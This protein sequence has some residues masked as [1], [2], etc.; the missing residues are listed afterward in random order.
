VTTDPP[1]DR[2]GRRDPDRDDARRARRAVLAVVT[3]V[4]ATLVW[5]LGVPW[6]IVAVAV[7]AFVIWLLVEG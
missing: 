6:P 1:R 2:P 7:G 4:V 5:A 3:I